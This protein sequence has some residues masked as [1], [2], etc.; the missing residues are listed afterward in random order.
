MNKVL[1]LLVLLLAGC[2]T[3]TPAALTEVTL[4]TG[5]IP[6]VQFAPLYVAEKKGYFAAEGLKVKVTWGLEYDGVKL[7]GANQVDFAFVGGDQAVQARAQGIPLVYV[8]N[9][10]NAFP[11]A[12]FS[13]KEKNIATPKDLIGKKV[14]LPGL[15]GASYTAW[16]ALLYAERIQESDVTVQ[17]IGFNQVQAVSQGMVDAAVG[18]ANNEPVQLRLAGKEINQINVWEYSKLVGNGIA[19]NEKAI[20][21]QPKIVRGFVRAFLKGV[22]DTIANPDEALKIAIENVPE[23]GGNNFK[24]GEAVLNASIALWKNSRLGYVN[25]ADWEATARFMKDAG[26]IQTEVDVG[27]VYTNEFVP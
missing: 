23:A 15:F 11:S 16:R 14:G 5:Y 21:E 3:A 20:T 12:V 22:A 13:L 4:V 17:V 7:V 24:T 8:A 26:F 9:W 2:A 19:V 6:N 27:K 1:I 18:Y 10:Y 25:P